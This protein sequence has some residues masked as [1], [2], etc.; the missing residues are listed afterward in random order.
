MILKMNTMTNICFQ[1][2]VI[3]RFIDIMV[4]IRTVVGIMKM[5][6]TIIYAHVSYCIESY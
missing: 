6:I 4:S 1:M 3:L 5:S 2:S